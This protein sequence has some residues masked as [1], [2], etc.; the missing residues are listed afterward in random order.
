MDEVAYHGT[1]PSSAHVE[2][3]YETMMNTVKKY[4]ES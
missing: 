4:F 2:E 3:G 1:D